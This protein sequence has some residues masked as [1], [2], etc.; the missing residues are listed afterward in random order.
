MTVRVLAADGVTPVSGATIGWSASNGLQ[1]SACGG[2]SSCSVASD[3]NGDAATWLTPAAVGAATI[4]ATLAPGVYSSSPSVSATLNATESA[5][6]IGVLTPYLWIAQ[7]AT[8]SVPLTARVLSNGAPQNNVT[9]NFTVVSGS[10][11]LS[12]ASAQTSSTG[13]ATV[14]LT[15][16][17][18]HGPGTSERLRGS[19]ERPLPDRFM[20][21][22]AA[23]N[24]I[25]QP[26]WEAGRFLPARRFNRSWCGSRILLRRRIP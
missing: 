7:G 4:T 17:A 3:Q 24:R 18:I 23:L 9:V 8:V 6:D 10:G 20:Q 11:T 19:G 21:T 12:A 16:D 5:S 13:Y 25:L 26:V 22:R 2:A 15:V 1:L 14:T